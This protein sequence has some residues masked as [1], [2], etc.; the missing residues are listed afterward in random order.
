MLIPARGKPSGIFGSRQKY[1][2]SVSDGK[3]PSLNVANTSQAFAA[4]TWSDGFQNSLFGVSILMKY[5]L[6]HTIPINDPLPSDWD[7][8]AINELLTKQGQP[9]LRARSAPAASL[10]PP[11]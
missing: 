5:F 11:L 6:V 3:P 10:D 2:S 4:G 1:V 7:L 8:D 9:L